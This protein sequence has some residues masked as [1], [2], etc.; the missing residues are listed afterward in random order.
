MKNKHEI[1]GLITN[2]ILVVLLLCLIVVGLN[3]IGIY[4]LPEPVEKLL[5]S[6]DGESNVS[7]ENDYLSQGSWEFDEGAAS[8]ED[9]Q[10]GYENAFDVLSGL[11]ARQNYIHKT[12]VVNSYGN[13][14]RTELINIER[15]DGLYSISVFDESGRTLKRISE[16]EQGSVLITEGNEADSDSVL[17]NKGDFEINDETGFVLTAR[18]FLESGYNLSSAD[19]SQTVSE[20]GT[21]IT[22][23]FD[24]IN[25]GIPL[26]QRYVFSLDYGV[27]VEAYSYENGTLVYEMTTS[28]ISLVE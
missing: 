6:F 3:Y 22:V 11:D 27:A 25:N 23:S 1:L 2:F 14:S 28:E 8:L 10:L 17:V 13:V 24:T 7:K 19:F 20:N 26:R 15:K 5:G 18:E 4:S 16:N 12:K 9:I 21:F